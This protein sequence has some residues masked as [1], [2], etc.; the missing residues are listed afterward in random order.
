METD[1]LLVRHA[2]QGDAIAFETLMESHQHTI[3]ALCLRMMGSRQDALDMAQEAMLRIYRSLGSF[4]AQANF[5]TWIYR[6]TAN[7]CIDELRKRKRT[8]TVSI[9]VLAQS[10]FEPDG[11]SPSPEASTL[12]KET[13]EELARAI[14]MLPLDQRTAIVLRDV[15]GLSY[16]EVAGAMGINLN[17]VKSR[18]SR[19][20]HRLRQIL[21]EIAEQTKRNQ[22]LMD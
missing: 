13:R 21:L 8:E 4:K 15:Q 10:G 22:S 17:T 19:G 20:R 5:S 18:I 7:V 9:D 14:M 2:S 3:Y 16:E 12:S 6:I 11:E 1:A